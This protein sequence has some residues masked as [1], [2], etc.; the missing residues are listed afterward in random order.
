MKTLVAEQLTVHE[1]GDCQQAHQTAFSVVHVEAI[2]KP[3]LRL[4]TDLALETLA[5]ARGNEVRCKVVAKILGNGGALGQDDGLRQRRSSNGDQGRFAERVNG[6]E[7]SRREL[8]GLSLVHFYIVRGVLGAFF[9]KPDNTL[10]TRF[11][12]PGLG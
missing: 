2:S 5:V 10:G 11:L 4:A 7:L 3:L 9:E 6:L 12:E 8:V 1:H